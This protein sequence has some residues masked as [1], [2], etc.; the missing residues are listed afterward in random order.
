LFNETIDHGNFLELL[1]FLSKFDP[2]LK[3][4]LKESCEKSEEH[5]KS[6]IE[7][8]RVGIII[9]KEEV[10]WRHFY[11]KQWSIIILYKLSQN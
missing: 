3:N 2:F 10:I 4:H 7:N 8:A 1:I 9:V 11:L 6:R 5:R